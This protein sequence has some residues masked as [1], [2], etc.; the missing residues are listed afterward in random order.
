MA[1]DINDIAY[2]CLSRTRELVGE[3]EDSRKGDHDPLLPR[4]LLLDEADMLVHQIISDTVKFEPARIP[5]YIGQFPGLLKKS[6]PGATLEEAIKGALIDLIRAPF[7][8]GVRRI[9]LGQYEGQ[10]IG[11]VIRAFAT[12]GVSDSRHEVENARYNE[13]WRMLAE[14]PTHATLSR[15]MHRAT[16]LAEHLHDTGIVVF[17]SGPGYE[18][19]DARP[20]EL[21]LWEI[22]DQLSL[23]L[24]EDGFD[25][26]LDGA[27]DWRDSYRGREGGT[28]LN[29]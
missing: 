28:T 2:R 23:Q 21:R 10:T 24:E 7:A 9:L 18:E 8:S 11:D 13:A 1:I 19:R 16:I 15:M 22:I 3:Y 27:D 6:H 14:N 20:Y 25:L 12:V 29:P 4:Y 26:L 5:E 17:G